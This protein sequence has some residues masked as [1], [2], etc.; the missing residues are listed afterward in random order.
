VSGLSL[1]LKSHSGMSGLDAI[2]GDWEDL[3]G[4]IGRQCFYH[5]PYWFKA[6]LGASPEVGERIVFACIYRGPRLVAVFPTIW[7]GGGDKGPMVVELPFG[8]QLYSADCAISDDEDGSEI[9]DYFRGSLKEIT[10]ARWDIYKARNFLRDGHLGKAIFKHKRFNQ[11][12]YTEKFCAEIPIGDYD[13]AIRNL[14]GK[15]RG[16]LNNAKNRLK[17][18]G[19]ARFEVE[20]SADGVRRSF[21]D[22]VELEMS[23][24]KGD[25]DNPRNDYPRPSAIG[26]KERKLNF[27]K[28]M[29]DQFARA[30]CVEISNLILNDKLIGSEI[31]LL[32]NDTSYAVKVAYDE[33]AGRYSPGHLLIDFAYRRYADEGQIKHYNQ[34]TDFQWFDNWNPIHREY[35]VMRDFNTSISGVLACLRSKVGAKARD[36]HSKRQ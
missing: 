14:K 6:Y 27:Y 7:S 21:N 5:Q 17:K 9:Y 23:G 4:R 11:T 18:A 19:E 16:N 13:E 28:N 12:A 35:V 10:G 3:M 33:N 22:F 8:D 2:F 15:F 26:L 31:C 20:R 24:W 34:I 29:I 36:Y 32:L 30:G 1:E 25:R